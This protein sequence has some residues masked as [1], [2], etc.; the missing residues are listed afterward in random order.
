MGLKV[1]HAGCGSRQVH[2]SF[3]TYEEVRLDC[4]INCN[5][6]ILA[7][8]VSMPMIEEEH[9]D[10]VYCAHCLE[11]LYLH[12]VPMAIGEFH[13]VLKPGGLLMLQTP[14][15]HALAGAIAEDKVEWILYQSDAG[16]ITVLDMIFG[17]RASVAMGNRAMA[18]HSGFTPKS[19]LRHLERAG[20]ELVVCKP[21][22]ALNLWATARRGK[23]Q[24][25]VKP[26]QNSSTPISDTPGSN[27]I[28]STTQRRDCPSTSVMG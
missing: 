18:H 4:D 3:T 21:D 12:E 14:N 2:S 11:H 13:R 27:G 20:F 7:S 6:D 17:H 28:T 16:P 5:P 9:F 24:Q 22:N 26:N 8:I 10:A 19:M 1:L 25:S 23:C 15:L